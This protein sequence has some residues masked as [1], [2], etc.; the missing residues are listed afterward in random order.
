MLLKWKETGEV[1]WELLLRVFL[2][3]GPEQVQLSK[4]DFSELLLNGRVLPFQVTGLVLM[5]SRFEVAVL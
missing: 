4:T 3:L 2:R 1:I 5:N